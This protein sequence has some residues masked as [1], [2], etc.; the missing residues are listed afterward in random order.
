MNHCHCFLHKGSNVRWRLYLHS[1]Q[2]A[3]SALLIVGA[4]LQA[5][6]WLTLFRGRRCPRA[7]VFHPHFLDHSIFW[8]SSSSSSS[9]SLLSLS[10]LSCCRCHR[11]CRCVVVCASSSL[12]CLTLPST[13]PLLLKA[14]LPS[15]LSYH[16]RSSVRHCG[17][18]L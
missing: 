9:S 17:R 5:K 18:R 3:S 12:F 11:R 13:S 4:A 14:S 16:L 1:G 2:V 10:S 15:Y 7:R 6:M 8:L